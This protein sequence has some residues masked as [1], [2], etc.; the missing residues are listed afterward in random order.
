MNSPNASIRFFDEQ[1]QRQIAAENY[2]L[3]PFEL[4]A[5]PHLLGKTLDFGCGDTRQMRS[6]HGRGIQDLRRFRHGIVH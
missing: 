2:E 1:F 5:L 6:H 3:N 4:A